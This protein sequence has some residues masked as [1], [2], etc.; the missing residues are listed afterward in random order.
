MSTA[1]VPDRK[2]AAEVASVLLCRNDFKIMF[3]QE[4]LGLVPG[5]LRSLVVINV[6]PPAIAGVID[7]LSHKDRESVW[8]V[9]GRNHVGS[10]ELTE[11]TEEPTTTIGLRANQIMMAAAGEEACMDFYQASAFSIH[12]G[13][14]NQKLSLDPIVR[15]EMKFSLFLAILEKLQ[16]LDAQLKRKKE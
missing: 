16:E 7:L 2:Y 15:V 4:K 8:G 11:I 10:G 12:A 5:V 13:S 3:G 1:P 6:G 9:A 14:I